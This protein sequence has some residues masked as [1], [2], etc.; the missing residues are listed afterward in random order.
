MNE[1]IFLTDW[2]IIS[3]LTIAFSINQYLVKYEQAHHPN[4]KDT[5][6]QK[7]LSSKCC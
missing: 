3:F 6:T 4:W 7:K 1:R 2:A 5:Q